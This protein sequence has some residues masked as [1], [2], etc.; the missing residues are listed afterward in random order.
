MTSLDIREDT[1]SIKVS[2]LDSETT[3]DDL[4]YTFSKF[5]HVSNIYVPKP[6]GDEYRGIRDP[7]EVRCLKNTC[8]VRYFAKEEADKA[9]A[10]L[11]GKEIDGRRLELT[12]QKNRRYVQEVE[13]QVKMMEAKGIDASGLKK[14]LAAQGIFTDD[15]NDR[16]QEKEERTSSS[17][18]YSQRPRS[19]KR[20]HTRYGDRHRDRYDRED[21]R[22]RYDRDRRDRRSPKARMLPGSRQ[23]K[24][25]A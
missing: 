23:A 3:L 5:G 10:K 6:P 25:R 7:K 12:L 17:R 8:F 9:I 14:E 15:P 24:F 20:E 16:K 21:R 4:K 22:D 18:S 11:H 19:P 2:N 13:M 1:F